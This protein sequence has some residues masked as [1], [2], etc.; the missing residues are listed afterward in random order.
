M[1]QIV[2]QLASTE[3]TQHQLA[4]EI[5]ATMDATDTSI[6]QSGHDFHLRK[7][8]LLVD[9]SD[10]GLLARRVLNGFYFLAQSDPDA[11]VHTYD[12]RY[13]KWLINYA[14][15]NNNVHLKHVIRE[16]Q[17][18]A[19]Q[20]NVVDVANPEADNYLSVPMLGPAGMRKGQIVFKI[21]SELRPQLRDP[22]RHAYLSMRIL[23]G[24]SSIYP[25]ELYERLSVFKAEGRT[26]W[27]H[28]DE[29]RSLIKVD[30]LKSANDFRYFRR[31]I[32]DPAVEQINRISDIDVQLELRR[33]GRSYSHI[34]F[35]V[36]PSQNAH[37]LSSIEASK[38]LYTALTGE[39]GLSDAELDEIAANR[40]EWPDERIQDAIA[41]V[42]HRCA[43][44]NVQYPGKYLMSALRD[45]YRV[46]SIEQAAKAAKATKAAAS[47]KAAVD[48]QSLLDQSP[49]KAITLPTGAE[50]ETTWAAFRQSPQ[51]RMFKGL[52][53]HF[54][55]ATKPQQKAFEGFLQSQ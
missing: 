35:T 15:S 46:G 18:S 39:F 26:P 12:L 54:E 19:V 16:A 8:S 27:W 31:D 10:I 2:S 7:S 28:L 14:N 32:L 51:S 30:G 44:S 37:L 50:L 6:T 33:T 24:F 25:L 43:T 4:L 38:Q 29:F 21:P 34:A 1:N 47:A 55:L 13:F 9:V 52:P 11:E 5:F 49:V 42:R 3:P 23:A 20:V 45:G 40:E 53:D 36:Q 17:K 48:R 22:A 41:F